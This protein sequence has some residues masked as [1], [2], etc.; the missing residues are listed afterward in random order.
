MGQLRSKQVAEIICNA[1]SVGGAKHFKFGHIPDMKKLEVHF[2][3]LLPNGVRMTWHLSTYENKYALRCCQ[4][5]TEFMLGPNG[6]IYFPT[7]CGRY[8]VW[9]LATPDHPTKP[10]DNPNGPTVLCPRYLIESRK[11]HIHSFIKDRS[12]YQFTTSAA[13]KVA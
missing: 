4:V 9:R 10:M 8:R 6:E 12:V 13:A 1:T 3:N 11:N 7:L 2:N 5:C